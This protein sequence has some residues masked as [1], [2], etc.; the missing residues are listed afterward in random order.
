VTEPFLG[1]KL[2]ILVGDRIVS[3]LRDDI[4]TIPWPGHWDIPGGAREGDETPEACVLREL[5]EELAIRLD[6][7]ALIYKQRGTRKGHDVW[8]FAAEVPDFDE[9]AVVFGNEGQMWKL[10]SIDW[11]LDEAH[12][13]PH[14]KDNLR[15]YLD[16]RGKS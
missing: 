14:Q 16:Q 5:E 11:F 3:I 12:A 9:A 15:Q 7:N 13:V 1:A 8:F 10:A 4:P 6:E 2:A